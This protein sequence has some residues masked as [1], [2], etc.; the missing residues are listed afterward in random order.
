VLNS[1]RTSS[2]APGFVQ[3]PMGFWTLVSPPVVSPP[4]TGAATRTASVTAPNVPRIIVNLLTINVEGKGLCP[5]RNAT[6]SGQSR[7]NEKCAADEKHTTARVAGGN[8]TPSPGG[9]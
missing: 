4:A 3:V 5:N 7:G 2:S 9:L 8:A 6:D 1:N